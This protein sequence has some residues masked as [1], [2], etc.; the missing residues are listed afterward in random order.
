MLLYVWNKIFVILSVCEADL[1]YSIAPKALFE[2][3]K[4]AAHGC[5]V[6]EMDNI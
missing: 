5:D 2:L 3:C 4:K 6:I 1:A